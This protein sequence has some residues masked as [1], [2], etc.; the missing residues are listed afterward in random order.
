VAPVL[1]K[2]ILKNQVGKNFSTLGW[3]HGSSSKVLARSWVQTLVPPKSK[4]TTKT[5][6]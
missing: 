4:T 6:F 5:Y 1:E 3:G 2:K